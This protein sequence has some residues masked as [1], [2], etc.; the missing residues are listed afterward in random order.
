MTY[1][2]TFLLALLVLVGGWLPVRGQAQTLTETG[3]GFEATLTETFDV[4]PGGTLT[5]DRVV[6]SIT[7][8]TW[9]QNRVEVT[10]TIRL[11]ENARS[12]A[13][14][15]VQRY[16]STMEQHGNAVS[17][18]GPASN[19]QDG[20]RNVRHAFE[21]RLP[22]A[23]EADV[24]T[25]GGS[26]DVEGLR[27]RV[28][29]TTSGGSIRV[30]DVAGAVRVTTSGG[31]LSLTGIDGPVE[32]HTSGGSIHAERVTDRLDVRTSGG[33]IRI[34]D[35]QAGVDAATAGGSVS[36]EAVRGVV[37]ARTSG[38]DMS[39]RAADG[40]VAVQTS[41]G[42]IDLAD[43]GGRAEARTSGGDIEGRTLR[44]SVRAETSAGDIEL[45]D[46]QAGVDARTSV[47]DIRVELTVEDFDT[48]YATR[49]ATSHGDIEITLPADLPAT[50]QA[51][52]RPLYRWDQDDILSDFPLSRTTPDTDR[53]STLRST[54]DINGGGPTIDLRTSG[55]S[56]R[57]RSESR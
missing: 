10:E 21:V 18:R 9:N 22:R 55:G 17:V 26:I 36:V 35:A 20:R 5:I 15:Y 3:D 47:G 53:A 44:G 25:A 4:A 49:L 52:V 23:F 54:G 50:I 39:V 13:Q 24:S 1:R 48:D 14:D 51:E 40:D 12:D 56:I 33:S 2:M 38:G 31:S 37:R 34:Y 41:G 42:D 19:R 29:A 7:V 16:R 11:D 30:H 57:I 8:S 6:G 46:V 32:G 27:G 28:S 43:I 45:E